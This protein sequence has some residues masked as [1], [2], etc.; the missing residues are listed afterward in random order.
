MEREEHQESGAVS[1]KKENSGNL[2]YPVQFTTPI[3]ISTR[4]VYPISS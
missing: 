2:F 4:T 3:D 1:A